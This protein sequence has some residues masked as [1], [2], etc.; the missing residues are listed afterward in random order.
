M[1]EKR[2]GPKPRGPFQDKRKTLTTRITEDTRARLDAAAQQT[3]RSLSQEIELRLEKSFLLDDLCLLSRGAVKAPEKQ[4]AS[5]ICKGC[6]RK[7]LVGPAVGIRSHAKFC[8]AKCRA[9]YHNAKNSPAEG[10]P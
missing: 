10:R 4:A 7:F 6:E 5:K 9:D 2:P 8:T 3:G 1:A